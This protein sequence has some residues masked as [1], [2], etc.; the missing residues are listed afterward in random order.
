MYSKN[1]ISRT[2]EAFW[3]T[4]GKYLSPVLSAEGT[5]VHW[6]NY[7]TGIKDIRF[8]MEAD[9]VKCMIGIRLSHT[10]PDLQQLFF[11]EFRKH[12][13]TLHKYLQEDW[14]WKMHEKDPNGKTHSVIYTELNDV[15]LYK[16][17]DWPAIISFLKPR[18]IALDA[19]WSDWKY[20]FEDLV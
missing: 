15:N 5:Q 17:E 20:A 7:K 8:F 11:E 19:F 3:T 9:A 16:R 1:E 12:D 6:V 2:K 4:F 13:T 14:T 18:L 10:E